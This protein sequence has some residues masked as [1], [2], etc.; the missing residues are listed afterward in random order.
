MKFL[1]V[2][3]TLRKY[4]P[5]TSL[6]RKSVDEYTFAGTNVT[7]PKGT[8]VWIPVYSLQHDPKI[9]P[10]PEKFDPERFSEENVKLRDPMHYLPFGD[11][12]RNCIGNVLTSNDI[13][14]ICKF[15]INR[16]SYLSFAIGLRFANYQSKVGLVKII[17]NYNVDVC[18]KTCI[19]YVKDTKA[20]IVTPKDGLY[21]TF[22]KI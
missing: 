20:F 21:L 15:S 6:T 1:V 8:M 11:G 18:D 9:Y 4:P 16:S 14:P 3:E 22:A 7:I 17:Q 19:P 13:G 2:L 10:D 5:G 12:P